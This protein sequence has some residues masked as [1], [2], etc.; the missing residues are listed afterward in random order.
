M[1]KLCAF[2]VPLWKMGWARNVNILLTETFWVNTMLKISWSALK[3]K[4]KQLEMIRY[5]CHDL[6]CLLK[7]WIWQNKLMERQ[8]S[9][10]GCVDGDQGLFIK[11]IFLPSPWF[12][13]KHP[14][15][16]L[17]LGAGSGVTR[18]VSWAGRGIS[19]FF[20]FDGTLSRLR[21]A[22]LKSARQPVHE[23]FPTSCKN[24]QSRVI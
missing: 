6:E 8:F 23:R 13:R 1:I 17:G 21:A 19:P 11:G 4:D 18:A 22:F 14:C 7:I 24:I 12:C 2:N 5:F 16:W 15:C 9:L 10:T 20:S 3:V